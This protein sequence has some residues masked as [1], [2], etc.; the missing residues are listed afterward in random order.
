MMIQERLSQVLT[1]KPTQIFGFMLLPRVQ[2]SRSS[3]C[4]GK[5]RRVKGLHHSWIR[6][7]RRDIGQQGSLWD[8]RHFELHLQSFSLWF[9][10]EQWQILLVFWNFWS[11]ALKIAFILL[12]F[13]FHPPPQFS[14]YKAQLLFIFWAVLLSEVGFTNQNKLWA[15]YTKYVLPRLFSLNLHL[16]LKLIKCTLLLYFCRIVAF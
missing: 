4:Q 1:T 10:V 7:V 3:F 8:V 9:K 14:A 15:I 2:P 5:C 11:W 13:F 12:W 16:I 6:R